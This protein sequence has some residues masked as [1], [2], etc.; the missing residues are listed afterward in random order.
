MSDNLTICEFCQKKLSNKANCERHKNTCKIKKIR[1]VEQQ[2]NLKEL[3]IEK[4]KVLEEKEKEKDK[5][6]ESKDKEIEKKNEQIE[7][8]K[9]I[10]N[11]YAQKS[12]TT[13]NN[14]Y[15]PVTNT[16]NNNFNAKDMVSNLEPIDFEE[17]KNS[18]HLYTDKYIDKGM[19]GFASFLCN[20]PC[21]KKIITTDY[22]RSIIAYR[23]KDKDYVRD[24]EASFLINTVI[25]DNSEVLYEKA[26]E[27]KNYYEEQVEEDELNIFDE[28]KQKLK[29]IKKMRKKVKDVSSGQKIKDKKMIGVLKNHGSGNM[30]QVI[31]KVE[32]EEKMKLS[33]EE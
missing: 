5:I 23:L 28:D 20:H 17:I 32:N 33:I 19:E 4:E 22:A 26:T 12:S 21:K 16:I 11:A 30:I 14:N 15:K 29:I 25:Q 7:F 9:T 1:E 18:M 8:L 27:R 24:P 3:I 6:I 31:E 13:I 2:Q 10:I